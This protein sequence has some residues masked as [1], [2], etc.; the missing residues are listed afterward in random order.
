MG[1]WHAATIGTFVVGSVNYKRRICG[2]RAV[3]LTAKN[4]ATP[5]QMLLLDG[6]RVCNQKVLG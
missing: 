3:A 6:N 5:L 1:G 2:R 4:E